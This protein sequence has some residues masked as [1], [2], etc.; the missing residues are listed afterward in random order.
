MHKIGQSKQKEFNIRHPR[1]NVPDFSG[2]N[3]YIKKNIIFAKH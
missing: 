3:A 1:A 2:L